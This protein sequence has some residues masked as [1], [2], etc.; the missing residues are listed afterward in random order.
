MS[1]IIRP[2]IET[3]ARSVDVHVVVPPRWAGTGV[4]EAD[5]A[6]LRALPG[7]TW[8]IFDSPDHPSLRT[9][10]SD[11]GAVLR[12]VRAIDPDY[13]F[14]RSADVV[15]PCRFP[16]KVGFLMEADFPPLPSRGRIRLSGAGIFD[17]GVMPWLDEGQRD[18]LAG[19]T[20]PLLEAVRSMRR[21]DAAGRA[22][23]FDQT[24]LPADRRVIALP[25]EHDGEDNFYMMHSPA[26]V[27]EPFVRELA[28]RLGDDCVLALTIHPAQRQDRAAMARLEG[29]ACDRVRILAPADD[30]D[31][32]PAL[33]RHCDG[34]IVRDS[35]SFVWPALFGKPVFRLSRFASAPW[36]NVYSDFDALQTALRS[37]RPNVPDIEEALVWIGFH[38][39]NNAFLATDPDL[40]LADLIDRVERPFHPARWDLG[41]EQSRADLL[42]AAASLHSIGA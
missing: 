35:K 21:G 11:P 37:G 29:L 20:R 38:L 9:T 42:A 19:Q 13:S 6:S 25:L 41:L 10:P 36:L 39:A 2:L 27:N 7:T 26:P 18:W 31:A 28:A 5:L 30:G 3:A 22:R 33:A 16:G 23:L 15:T 34:M 1:A 14:C 12:I 40:A 8:H 17:H 24:G 32:T 4:G